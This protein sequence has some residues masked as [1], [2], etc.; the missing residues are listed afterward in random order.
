[1]AERP[2]DSVILEAFAA[3]VAEGSRVVSAGLTGRFRVLERSPKGPWL[4]QHLEIDR[5]LGGPV[6]RYRWKTLAVCSADIFE[7][8]EAMQKD[9]AA[10]T[11]AL[12]KRG[13][14]RSRGQ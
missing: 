3:E 8:I 1:M 2:P 4:V 13:S 7:G 14:L 11:E 12:R 10:W 6:M 9:Q 5:S